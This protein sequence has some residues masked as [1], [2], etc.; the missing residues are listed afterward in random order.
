L[1]ILYNFNAL[2]TTGADPTG[3][4][5]LDKQGNLYGA[6]AYGGSNKAGTVFVVKP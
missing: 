5:V 6:T 3:A 2:G 4:L 1:T